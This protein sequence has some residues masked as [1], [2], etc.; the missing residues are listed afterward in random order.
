MTNG[1]SGD[2]RANLYGSSA[3]GSNNVSLASFGGTQPGYTAP[4]QATLAPGTAGGTVLSQSIAYTFADDPS[5]PGANANLLT[6]PIN[7]TGQVYSG[8]MVW[9]GGTADS[10]WASGGNWN[11]TQ[12]PT[13]AAV[14]AAPGLD[15]NYT[16]IDTAT[17]DNVTGSGGT[18]NLNNASPS[19]QA[20]TFNT[21]TGASYT[22]AQGSGTGTIN[23]SDGADVNVVSGTHLISAPVVLAGSL[24]VSTTSG[25]SLELSG[26][27][28]E[29]TPGAGQ[30][31]LSGDGQL[32]LSGT[33]LYNGGTVVDGGT[34]LVSSPTALADGSSLTVGD[35]GGGGQ[36]VFGYPAG[37]V[38]FAAPPGAV[39]TSLPAV[40]PAVTFQAVPEPGTLALLAAGAAL[41]ALAVWRRRMNLSA[42]D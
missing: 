31:V 42:N 28:G 5:L 30:L 35:P 41:A 11:D 14:H 16:A 39:L 9:S 10:S 18:I 17:F 4:L 6:L 26:D 23:L 7:I 25:A 40:S 34:L 24:A 29:A 12:G 32:I 21:T 27:V 22:L 13:P 15:P 38:P 20:I 33:G 3:A 8:K 1:S 2:V 19:L 36:V 37:A